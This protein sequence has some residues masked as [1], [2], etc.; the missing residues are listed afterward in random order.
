MEPRR[1]FDNLKLPYCLLRSEVELSSLSSFPEKKKTTVMVNKM[2]PP[3]INLRYSLEI[4][5]HQMVFPFA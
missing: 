4:S 3:N 2:T 5:F 1:N